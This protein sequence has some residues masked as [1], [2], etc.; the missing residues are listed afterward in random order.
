MMKKENPRSRMR[1]AMCTMF[2]ERDISMH[3]QA[4]MTECM[5]GKPDEVKEQLAVLLMEIVSTSTTEEEM[6]ARAKK[7]R[8]KG[9][10][11]C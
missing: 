8:D 7:L 11:L 5:Y 6:I 4:E 3:T 9:E 2:T 1:C 10:K